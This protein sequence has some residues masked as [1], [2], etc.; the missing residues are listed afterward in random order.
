MNDTT[1]TRKAAR[2]LS[3]K[4]IFL[5]T[6]I[7]C[8]GALGGA[9]ATVWTIRAHLQNIAR[10]PSMADG[11]SSKVIEGVE[12]DLS[13]HLDLTPEE[14]TGLQEEL[15]ITRE[16]LRKKRGEIVEDLHQI[17]LDSLERMEKRVAAEKRAALR[18]RVRE[19]LEPWGLEIE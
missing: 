8:L 9:G 14:Q 17:A 12:I 7:F 16:L 15:E 1:D 10:D 19:R 2:M 6:A 5:L 4:A 11:P 18:D 3:L 13:R